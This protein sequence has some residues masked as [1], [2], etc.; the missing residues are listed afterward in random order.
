MT[1]IGTVVSIIVVVVV[2]RSVIECK[3]IE[4]GYESIHTGIRHTVLVIIAGIFVIIHDV[5][6]VF[7]LAVGDTAEGG[8]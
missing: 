6:A 8:M 1:I 4:L 5:I 7:Q 3:A 2:V